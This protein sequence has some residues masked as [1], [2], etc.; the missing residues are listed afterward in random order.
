MKKIMYIATVVERLLRLLIK[1]NLITKTEA[2]KVLDV[3]E[4]EVPA[5]LT[6]KQK[7]VL[8]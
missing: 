6:R 3:N 1:K 4:K 2:K 7:E 8:P 5:I